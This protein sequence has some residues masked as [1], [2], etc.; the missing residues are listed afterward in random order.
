MRLLPPQGAA[1]VVLCIDVVV[2]VFGFLTGSPMLPRAANVVLTVISIAVLFGT[3]LWSKGGFGYDSIP[4]MWRLLRRRLPVW[5][6]VAATIA[7]WGGVFLFAYPLLTVT[8]FGSLDE[9]ANQ[10]GWT[11]LAAAF[12]SGSLFY[13]GIGRRAADSP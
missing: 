9:T 2:I 1:F 7:F 8:D 11:G 5:L 13:A 4:S 3:L 12:A 6:I 10:R